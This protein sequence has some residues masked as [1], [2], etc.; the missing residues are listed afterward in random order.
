MNL[1]QGSFEASHCLTDG[2]LGPVQLGRCA[3]HVLQ[4]GDGLEVAQ[5]AEVHCKSLIYGLQ[6][7][8]DWTVADVRPTLRFAIPC[9]LDWL[10]P[11]LTKT[12]TT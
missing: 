10:P 4:G 9:G 5:V 2:G 1:N 7:T 6:E 11:D 3:A 8:I 12:E